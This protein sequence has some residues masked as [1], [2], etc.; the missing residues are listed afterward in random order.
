MGK[1]SSSLVFV[2]VFLYLKLFVVTKPALA[3]LAVK[4]TL[5]FKF[6]YGIVTEINFY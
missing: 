6:L 2:A 1:S 3:L 5:A 4:L